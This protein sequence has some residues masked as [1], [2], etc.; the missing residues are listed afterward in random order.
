MRKVT[1]SVTGVSLKLPEGWKDITVE[2][3]AKCEVILNK[4]KEDDTE[5]KQVSYMSQIL[6]LISDLESVDL[7]R[8]HP[9]EVGLLFDYTR[10]IL[11]PP[12][13][14]EVDGFE[15]D[16]Y[17]SLPT[18]LMKSSNFDE[19]MDCMMVESLADKL[20]GNFT[21]MTKIIAILVNRDEEFNEEI[22]DDRVE[23]FKGLTMDI[24]WQV[25][26]FIQKQRSILENSLATY[27]EGK[28][29]TVH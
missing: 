26:F 2:Q 24:V 9:E 25:F 7:G 11:T 28:T 13:D 14:F 3:F 15:Y 22:Y 19:W 12:P 5:H 27:G 10:K 21:N 1:T 29:V 8:L 6:L 17:W 18:Q 16:G 20:E 4:I 23:L